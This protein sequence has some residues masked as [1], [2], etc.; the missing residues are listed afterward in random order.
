MRERLGVL[1]AVADHW[2]LTSLYLA[3]AFVAAVLLELLR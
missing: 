3:V 1:L 2:R